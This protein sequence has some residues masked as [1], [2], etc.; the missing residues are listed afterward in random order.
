MRS[1]PAASTRRAASVLCG[2][3]GS[4]ATVSGI[5]QVEKGLQLL[6]A[7]PG[8]VDD[9]GEHAP[10]FGVRPLRRKPGPRGA[11]ARKRTCRSGSTGAWDCGAAGAAG[12]PGVA[13]AAEGRRLL[14]G[15]RAGHEE[16]ND[17]PRRPAAREWRRSESGEVVE[18]V[19]ERER[20][21]TYSE[22]SGVDILLQLIGE[23]PEFLERAHL[24]LADRLGGNAQLVTDFLQRV[25]LPADEREAVEQDLPFLLLQVTEEAQRVLLEGLSA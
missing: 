6:E 16:R 10:L 25:A 5:G 2:R 4:T 14:T 3:L 12:A 19:R 22:A 15:R 24:D 18:R 9:E 21:T 13:G 20:R 11:A 7:V 8:I 17:T 23:A 1:L